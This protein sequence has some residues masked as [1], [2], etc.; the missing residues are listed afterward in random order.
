MRDANL[1]PSLLID[2][3][4]LSR[5]LSVSIASCWRWKSDGKLPPAISLSSQVVRWRRAD[6]LSWIDAGCIPL[7]ASKSAKEKATE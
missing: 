1:A 4:E 5:L 6:V 3:R 7:P 2:V